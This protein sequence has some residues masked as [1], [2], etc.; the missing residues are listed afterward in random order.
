MIPQSEKEA[1][2]L[3]RLIKKMRFVTYTSHNRLRYDHTE[4]LTEKD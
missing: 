3:C 2:S 4:G 1:L